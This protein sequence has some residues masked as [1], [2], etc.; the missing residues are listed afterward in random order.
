[1]SDEAYGKN[2]K[3][4]VFLDTD[5]RH[6]NLII[7]LRH[8]GLT[9]SDF[10]RSLITGYIEGDARIQDYIDEI[11][12]HSKLKKKRSRKLRQTGQEQLAD[13]GLSDQQVEN[14]FDLIAEE[15]PEL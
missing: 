9:Q 13:M 1:M 5:H 3:K 12:T 4:I 10:F 15:F 6:A 7:R 8:D 2:T 14:I 11:S